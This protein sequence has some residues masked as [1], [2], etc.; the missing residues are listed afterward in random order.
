MVTPRLRAPQTN[1]QVPDHLLT[2][3]EKA[4]QERNARAIELADKLGLVK[5]SRIRAEHFKLILAYGNDC[6][7]RGASSERAK[8]VANIRKLAEAIEKQNNPSQ[9]DGEQAEAR[10]SMVRFTSQIADEIERLPMSIKEVF[11]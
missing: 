7:R 11:G 5:D 3:E 4:A 1:G 2:R 6:G 9:D 10:A 8:L